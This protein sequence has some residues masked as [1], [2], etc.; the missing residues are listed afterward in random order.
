[1][2]TQIKAIVIDTP[3]FNNIKEAVIAA[4]LPLLTADSVANGSVAVRWHDTDDSLEDEMVVTAAVVFKA[5]I[6]AVDGFE[7]VYAEG[8]CHINFPAMEV[9]DG[10]EWDCNSVEI[11]SGMYSYN[12]TWAVKDD[13]GEL[14][15]NNGES[16]NMTSAV[17]DDMSN[18]VMAAVF[19]AANIND[20]DYRG[21]LHAVFDI[22][23]KE[24]HAQE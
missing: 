12:M 23:N 14:Q 5:P 20:D 15:H 4:F 19:G 22:A 10:R 17:D 6:K 8:V 18:D 9:G 11:N 13:N 7:P 21:F 16:F 1:M 24:D 2:T 3:I